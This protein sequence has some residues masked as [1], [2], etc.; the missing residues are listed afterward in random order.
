MAWQGYATLKQQ[1]KKRDEI[2]NKAQV[3]LQKGFT[4]EQVANTVCNRFGYRTSA[5][6]N[7][8]QIYGFNNDEKSQSLRVIREVSITEVIKFE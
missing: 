4:S 1:N 3:W 6:N 7:K 8:V 2:A 5:K